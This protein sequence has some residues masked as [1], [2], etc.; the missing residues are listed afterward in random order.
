VVPTVAGAV[1]VWLAVDV[2]RQNQLGVADAGLW[3]T[4]AAAYVALAA[5][6]LVGRWPE[7]RRMGLLILWWLLTAVGDDVGVVWPGSRVAVTALL[8]VL[9]LQAPAYAHM[10]L[11]YP[12]GYVRDR[13]ERIF[14]VVA[15]TVSLLWEL[16]P[17]LFANA[18]RSCTPHASSLLFTGHTFDLAPVGRVFWSLFIGLGVAFIALVLRRLRQAPRGARRTL[19]PLA[20]AGVFASAQLIVQRVAWLTGSD[21]AQA[22]LDWLARANLMI[23]PLAMAIG[24]TT[25]RRHRGLVGDLVVELGSAGPREIR[26]ALARGVG[27]PSLELALWLPEREQFVNEHGAAVSIRVDTPERAVTLI[28]PPDRPLAALVHDASLAGQRPLLEAA[29]SAARLAL[30]NARLHAE[31]RAQLGELRAS[32]ARIVA[33]AE[34]ERRRLE[35]DLHD[36]AQQ[37]LLALGLAL[38]LLDDNSSDRELLSEARTEL[39]AALR[40]LRELA[41]GIHPSILTDNGLPAAIGSLID[42]APIPITAEVA[43]GRYPQPVESAIYFVASEAL[44]NIAKHAQARSATVTVASRHGQLVVEIADDGRGGADPVSGGG[45]EGLADR[46]GALDGQL[47][48]HSVPGAGTT[49]RAEIPC[50]FS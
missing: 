24:V 43:D 16:P 44:A 6:V 5:A 20:A 28:G 25:I 49:I 32:R 21:Q 2:V 3:F 29:G 13:L 15:Y 42:R 38:Q 23:V 19:L 8:L 39:Q 41:R 37:R 12:S 1:G 10:A 14:V 26:S 46:V 4:A 17:A 30:E 27:D 11:A 50:E 47:T 33:S 7:R 36:G 22:T 18:C 35:R 40:E 9:A 31:L 48:I 45:L 34:S